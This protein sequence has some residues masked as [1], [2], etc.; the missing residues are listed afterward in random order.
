MKLRGLDP[1]SHIQVSS[2][3]LYIPRI[4]LPIWLSKIGRMI[5]GIYKSFTDT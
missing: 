4:G 3:S 1:N 5:L 2:C